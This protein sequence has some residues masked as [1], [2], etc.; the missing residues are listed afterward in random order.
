VSL[1][2]AF[3]ATGLSITIGVAIGILSGYYRGWVDSVLSRVMD[4]LLAFPLLLLAIGVAAAC[5]G[6]GGCFGGL[7]HPG[8]QVV[9]F[10]IA[11]ANWPYIARVMRGQV[12]SLRER[13]FVEAARMTGASDV[14]IMLREILPNLAAP[15]IVYASLI[16]P[17]NVLFEAALSF[18]GVGVNPPQASWGQMISDSISTFSTAWWYFLFPGVFLVL[19]V[20]AFNLVGDGLRDAL[21]GQ[22]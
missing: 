11:F 21:E 20:F 9:I 5:G 2:I 12:L 18:L 4:V 16:I 10:V 3:I 1:V 17:T 22:S 8:L 19:T 15:I 13:E 14:R 7:I 6:E